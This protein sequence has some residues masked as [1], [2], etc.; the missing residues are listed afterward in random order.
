MRVEWVVSPLLNLVLDVF[1][2]GAPARLMKHVE[3]ILDSVRLTLLVKWQEFPVP[4][5]GDFRR[6][7]GGIKDV[8]KPRL[9]LF[10]A[11]IGTQAGG[12]KQRDMEKEFPVVQSISAAI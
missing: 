8:V 1:S 11:L 12:D 6:T 4:R 7:L 3:Q 2:P 9:R 5:W 10:K